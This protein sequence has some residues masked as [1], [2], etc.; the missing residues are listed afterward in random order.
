M[1]VILMEICLLFKYRSKFP[2][3]RWWIYT[4]RSEDAVHRNEIKV[5]NLDNSLKEGAAFDFSDRYEN[6]EDEFIDFIRT[7]SLILVNYSQALF[8]R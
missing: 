5:R 2:L 3:W 4:D 8:S 1:V 7:S 6:W